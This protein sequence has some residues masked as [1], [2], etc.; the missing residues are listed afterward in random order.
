[1]IFKKKTIICLS[2]LKKTG[3]LHTRKLTGPGSYLVFL[4][5][6]HI[7]FQDCVYFLIKNKTWKPYRQW[8]NLS[9]GHIKNCSRQSWRTWMLELLKPNWEAMGWLV[10]RLVRT[11]A[12]GLL[13]MRTLFTTEDLA[14]TAATTQHLGQYCFLFL[15]LNFYLPF[16]SGSFCE[17]INEGRHHMYLAEVGSRTIITL[18]RW[19]NR[20]SEVRGTR[21]R[22][23]D[24]LTE[25]GTGIRT[26]SLCVLAT[27]A[28]VRSRL[29]QR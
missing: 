2:K 4:C 27:K 21:S 26:Q 3:C 13:E 10:W 9:K 5:I 17:P 15:D 19:S 12:P 8:E 11:E 18:R 14:A 22:P 16:I 25:P 6:F 7:F 23:T 29:H 24:H 28:R 1:M 20:N